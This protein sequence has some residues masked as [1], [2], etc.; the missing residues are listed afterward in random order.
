MPARCRRTGAA[1][2]STARAV[3]QHSQEV[4][5]GSALQLE[6]GLCGIR[7]ESGTVGFFVI[8]RLEND[9]HVTIKKGPLAGPH[10]QQRPLFQ[11][12]EA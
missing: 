3:T 8:V 10:L 11:A 4:G 1:D 5:P 12:V 2:A 9:E 6:V 7:Q